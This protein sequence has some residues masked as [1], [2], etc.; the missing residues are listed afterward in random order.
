[1]KTSP[2]KRQHEIAQSRWFIFIQSNRKVC[3]DYNLTVKSNSSDLDRNNELTL[4]EGRENL[5][6]FTKFTNICQRKTF[7]LRSFTPQTLDYLPNSINTIDK[8]FFRELSY[9]KLVFFF[10]SII[11]FPFP[12]K[13]ITFVYL[14]AQCG[15]LFKSLCASLHCHF[16]ALQC[17]SHN[18]IKTFNLLC[19][20]STIRSHF[21]HGKMIVICL[22]KG[23]RWTSPYKLLSPLYHKK[24]L[25]CNFIN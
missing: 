3:P 25:F 21:H 14:R 18:E 11:F 6:V 17:W 12:C 19:M 8:I 15:Y 20:L 24:N 1:M 10:H 5:F 22:G 16:L 2:T 7:F 23:K 4:A 9:L 13:V